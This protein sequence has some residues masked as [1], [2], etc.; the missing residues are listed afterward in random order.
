MLKV[1]YDKFT[2][3]EESPEIFLSWYFYML[4]PHR[5]LRIKI[6]I[7]ILSSNFVAATTT[8][9]LKGKTEEP[10]PVSGKKVGNLR[11]FFVC[12]RVLSVGKNNIKS[13]MHIY[14]LSRLGCVYNTLSKQRNILVYSQQLLLYTVFI[15]N[16]RV[17]ALFTQD[18][19]ITFKSIIRWDELL[20]HHCRS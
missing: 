1:K 3:L 19:C 2:F 20:T 11:D 14:L 7:N 9:M 12:F 17:Y 10:L 8:N 5:I 13:V 4:T 15:L 16:E 6:V 18:L